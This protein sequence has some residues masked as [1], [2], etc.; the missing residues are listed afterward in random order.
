MPFFTD[1]P[2]PEIAAKLVGDNPFS[3]N[4]CMPSADFVATL[5]NEL[6]RDVVAKMQHYT[7]REHLDFHEVATLQMSAL[8]AI[9]RI[10]APRQE[11]LKALA[12]R[13]VSEEFGL[14]EGQVNFDLDLKEQVGS[15]DMQPE[16]PD[17]E[18]PAAID[19]ETINDEVSK[20]RV[21]KAMI[22]GAARKGQYLF[23]MANRELNE[24]NPELENLYGTIMSINELCYF[25][26]PDSIANARVT[27]SDAQKIGVVQVDYS[28]A[29]PTVQAQAMI[30]PVLLHELFKGLMEVAASHGLPHDKA[31]R[32][33]VLEQ[34]EQAVGEAWDLRIGP[35]IWNKFIR[36]IKTEDAAL[37]YHLFHEVAKLP[38]G[39]FHQFMRGLLSDSPGTQ[40]TL[41]DMAGR[42][43]AAL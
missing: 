13:L 22:Q 12:I 38:P 16:Q 17:L 39:E 21:V 40:T 8:L 41:H 24:I 29:K 4:P 31:T 6:F 25:V 15:P 27:D 30:F 32:E 14:E 37:K 33:Y 1:R 10:E 35:G 23:H 28:D 7:G 34:A 42:I 19:Q 9:L 18:P 26:F 43:R 5:G 3:D 20:R 2:H 11:E 36:A